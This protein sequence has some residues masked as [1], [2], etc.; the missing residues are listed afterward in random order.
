MTYNTQQR[1]AIGLLA[2]LVLILLPLR[3]QIPYVSAAVQNG[4]GKVLV[5]VLPEGTDIEKFLSS[6]QVE[7]VDLSAL[8]GTANV[9]ENN[10]YDYSQPDSPQRGM[11]SE[12][13]V[14]WLSADDGMVDL[15]QYKNRIREEG[16]MVGIEYTPMLY[17]SAALTVEIWARG[18]SGEV[19]RAGESYKLK[20]SG[21]RV[22]LYLNEQEQGSTEVF[23]SG[24]HHIVA[25]FD[26]SQ[27]NY[28]VD[29]EINGIFKS[30][31]V[32]R[33]SEEELMIRGFSGNIQELKIYNRAFDEDK[34]Y[35]VFNNQA[36][37]MGSQPI[38]KIEQ[39]IIPF[40]PIVAEPVAS[41]IEIVVSATEPVATSTSIG[42]S[43]TSADSEPTASTTESVATTTEPIVP[44][45]G[46]PTSL[47]TEE[48]APDLPAGEDGSGEGEEPD[49]NIEIEPIAT[50]TEPVATT[51]EPVAS[52]TE[53]VCHP[54]EE[55]CD[56]L[57]NNCNQEIDEDC[58]C[59]ITSCDSLLNLIGECQND[60]LGTEGCGVCEPTCGCAEG[61][62]DCDDD[63]NNGCEIAGE[64]VALEPE[65]EPVATSTEPE[66][67]D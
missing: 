61:W 6:G 50:T 1:I 56:G 55:I 3:V 64:C 30:V 17:P 15:S 4:L 25:S 42:G 29:G 51:T 49:P 31:A 10:L 33:K 26:G 12:D 11:A 45:D 18:A 34:A 32:I 46:S 40:S 13:L 54:T 7:M 19:V 20:M 44:T 62:T 41:T 36:L 47:E 28:F 66:I 57:D 39:E 14:L 8:L 65:L 22:S 43:P 38:F 52:S 37:A 16:D 21:S 58:D 67:I 24:W 60:C 63:I 27:V 48:S 5:L 35:Q 9:S 2:L 53:P 23:G 59:G